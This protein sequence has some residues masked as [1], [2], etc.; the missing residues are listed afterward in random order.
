MFLCTLK[1][2]YHLIIHITTSYL[3]LWGNISYWLNRKEGH[4][5]NKQRN[6]VASPESVSHYL[7]TSTKMTRA[8][9][10]HYMG[11]TRMKVSLAKIKGIEL[12][13]LKVYLIISNPKLQIR[14]D[15]EDNSKIIFL[16]SQQKHML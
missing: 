7:K 1:E 4:P 12:L 3:E 2:N 15:I 11:L 13:P 6:R 14:G 10:K 5:G 9:Y 16:I 8:I